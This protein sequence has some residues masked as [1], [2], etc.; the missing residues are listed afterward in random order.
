MEHDLLF[1]LI[2]RYYCSNGR[3]LI[4]SYSTSVG[5][6]PTNLDWGDDMDICYKV[7]VSDRFRKTKVWLV[8][9]GWG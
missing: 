1:M 7:H 8:G 2:Y 6:I 9:G 5:S 4:T 3:V